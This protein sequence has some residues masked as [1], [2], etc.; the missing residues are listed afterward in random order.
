MAGQ[1]S[2][3]SYFSSKNNAAAALQRLQEEGILDVRL[4]RVS[5][6]E[7]DPMRYRGGLFSGGINSL[8]GVGSA[9][10]L[11]GTQTTE[12]GLSSSYLLGPTYLLTVVIDDA[13]FDQIK[14]VIENYG[15][16]V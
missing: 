12:S 11:D 10:V 14:T 7:Q 4:D 1:K 8:E 2:I 9:D 16:T 6:Y 3:L 5:L 13:Q 15:G